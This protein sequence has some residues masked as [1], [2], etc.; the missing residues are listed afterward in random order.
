[1]VIVNGRVAPDAFA[2]TAMGRKLKSSPWAFVV[3]FRP[4]A[5]KSAGATP[6]DARRPGFR[7]NRPTHRQASWHARLE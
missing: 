7:A 3:R 2:M 6:N 4:I 5:D 1:V